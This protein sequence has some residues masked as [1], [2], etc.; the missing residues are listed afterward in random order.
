MSAACIFLFGLSKNFYFSLVIRLIHGL[1]DGTLGVNKTI[2]AELSNSR[3]ISVGTSCI[4]ASGVIG[5]ICGPLFSSYL[6]DMNVIAPL[7]KIFP[8]LHDVLAKTFIHSSYPS[9]FP[10]SLS[11][12]SLCRSPSVLLV[13]PKIQLLQKKFKKPTNSNPR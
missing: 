3:N 5:R 1:A 11:L 4:V 2:V 12:S 13:L 6:T 7:V 8:F 9:S 10:S